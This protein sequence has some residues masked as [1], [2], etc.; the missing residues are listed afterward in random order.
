LALA[1]RVVRVTLAAAAVE[2]AAAQHASTSAHLLVPQI[3]GLLPLAAMAVAAVEAGL[4]RLD[5]E[6]LELGLAVLCL[7]EMV[8]TQHHIQAA[9]VA[10]AEP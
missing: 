10:E 4:S 3:L 8:A 9:A 1:Q 5:K 6:S 2:A 7:L